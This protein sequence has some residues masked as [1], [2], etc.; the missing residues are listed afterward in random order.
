M[1][2]SWF[3]AVLWLSSAH[4]EPRQ[5]QV[6][7]FPAQVQLRLD[8]QPVRSSGP[9]LYQVEREQIAAK[10]PH[11]KVAFRFCLEGWQDEIVLLSWNDLLGPLEPIRL[12]PASL[13]AY[14][15]CY[16]API[17][18]TLAL[19]LLGSAWLWRATRQ[20]KIWHDRDQ[21]LQDRQASSAVSDPFIGHSLGRFLITRKLGAGGMANVY[22]GES[23][24]SG[25]LV[26]IKVVRPE[27]LDAEFEARFRRE[28][29]VSCKLQHP[30][31]V[32]VQGGG[33][34]RGLPYLIMDYIRGFTVDSFITDQGLPIAQV[35]QWLPQLCEA[36]EYA[37][38]SGIVHRDL[39]PSNIMIDE[40]G[41]LLLM[42]FGLARSR[43]ASTLTA[44]GMALGT[45]AYV[46]PELL[47][48]VSTK[49][50]LTPLCDQY[51]LGVMVY[52]WLCGK[53][54][55]DSD[56]PARLAFLHIT[57]PPIPIRTYRPELSEKLEA[58][59]ARMLEKDPGHRFPS[60]GQACH[61]LML[62]LPAED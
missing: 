61:E 56:D 14:L 29:E 49:I 3:L 37:H 21:A 18:G 9:G 43:D 15:S 44:T 25:S 12:Q 28:I 47:G 22:L 27:E 60:V 6:D 24:E 5:F 58:T 51:S 10:G 54:P 1:R 26:A 35:K 55:I 32:S 50:T 13:M 38:Q 46:A 34:E 17:L 7:V 30:H 11:E 59:L 48:E 33:T 20:A 41:K 2:T 16:P 31:I 39:K 45:P 19:A 53:L 62:A 8:E 23:I 4:A 42:D 40:H 36:L 52:E 57:K